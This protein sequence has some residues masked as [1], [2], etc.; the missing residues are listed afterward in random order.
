M[1]VWDAYTRDEVRT[2]EKLVRGAPIPDGVY[3]L[4]SEILVCHV[5]GD[6]L[7]M[8]RDPTKRLSGLLGSDGWR[9]GIGW[10]RTDRLRQTGAIRGNGH[11]GGQ[12]DPDLTGNCGID[13]HHLPRLPLRYNGCE[14]CDPPTDGRN[15]GISVAPPGGFLH[16]CQDI[17][18]RGHDRSPEESPSALFERAI[19]G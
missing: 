10:R 13:T 18:H 7:L 17:R 16:I 2:G 15:G 12:P 1:E 14:G 5:D 19:P 6:F 11:R 8:Q 9:I 4:V 3:H